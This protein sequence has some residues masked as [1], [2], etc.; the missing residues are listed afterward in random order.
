MNAAHSAKTDYQSGSAFWAAGLLAHL[1]EADSGTGLSWVADSIIQV[2]READPKYAGTISDW[3]QKL[4]LATNDTFVEGLVRDVENIWYERDNPLNRAV[5]HLFAA[6]VKLLQGDEPFYKY[7]LMKSMMF[8]G[9]HEFC[10][11]SAAF[12]PLDLFARYA[13]ANPGCDSN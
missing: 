5:S 6:K 9:E 10:R 7:H 4:L 13:Q 1:E 11:Q 8:L 2:A 12:I 3:A